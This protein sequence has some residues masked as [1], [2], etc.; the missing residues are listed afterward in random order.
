MTLHISVTRMV[1][2]G[3]PCTLFMGDIYVTASLASFTVKWENLHIFR[4]EYIYMLYF[5]C[6]FPNS[7]FQKQNCVYFFHVPTPLFSVCSSLLL[8][9]YKCFLNIIT[10]LHTNNLSLLI[11]EKPLILFFH[12]GIHILVY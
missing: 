10:C 6:V 11:N 5:P 9:F 12:L 1:G 8:R 2:C 7:N 3:D 4:K